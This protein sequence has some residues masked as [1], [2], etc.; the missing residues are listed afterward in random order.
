M[1][2]VDGPRGR[3]KGEQIIDRGGDLG[4]TPVAVAHDAGDPARVRRPAAYDAPDLFSQGADNRRLGPRMVVV[5][6]RRRTPRQLPDDQGHP[7][8]EL[9]I[10]AAVEQIVLA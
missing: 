4:R 7:T 6:D 8:F 1:R 10:V 2:V 5:I 3:G 9:I